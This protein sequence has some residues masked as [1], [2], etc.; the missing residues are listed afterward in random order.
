MRGRP[1]AVATITWTMERIATGETA[2]TTGV[3]AGKARSPTVHLSR[4]VS[5]DTQAVISLQLVLVVLCRSEDAD[6]GDD[7]VALLLARSLSRAACTG[8]V[9]S[10]PKS[11]HR[12]LW[13]EAYLF[14]AALMRAVPSRRKMRLLIRLKFCQ[15]WLPREA[16]NLLAYVY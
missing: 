10:R 4:A 3:L 9:R 5:Q 1:Q 14:D 11:S 2:A 6:G 16:P 13:S 8:K 15:N 7:Q 12:E